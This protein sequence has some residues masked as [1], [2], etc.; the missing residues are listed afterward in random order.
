MTFAS[1]V[2]FSGGSSSLR[3]GSISSDDRR[4]SSSIQHLRSEL[5]VRSFDHLSADDDSL[6]TTAEAALRDRFS[7][8]IEDAGL[9]IDALHIASAD[10]SINAVVGR[11]T[12]GV[13]SRGTLRLGHG[14]RIAVAVKTLRKGA[15]QQAM[16]RLGPVLTCWSSCRGASRVI[17]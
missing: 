13:V 3:T 15:T 14:E 2:E 7:F 17:C 12:F 4:H 9:D 16:V 5:S 1:L 6:Y 8:L 10:L 11:G